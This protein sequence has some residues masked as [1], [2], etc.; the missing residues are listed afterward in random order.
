MVYISL[1]ILNH[2]I[3]III[4][5]FVIHDLFVHFKEN[6]GFFFFFKL[7][8]GEHPTQPTIPTPL[9]KEEEKKKGIFFNQ[10]A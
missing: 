4:L 3:F 1:H 9:N 10:I 7:R 6:I 5:Y 2:L 8:Q